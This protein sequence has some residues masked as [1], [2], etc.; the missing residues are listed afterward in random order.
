MARDEVP[1]AWIGQRVSVELRD[2]PPARVNV[3]GGFPFESRVGTL[4]SV[5][6]FGIELVRG[7]RDEF[8]PWSAVRGITLLPDT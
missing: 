8:H 6:E 2:P 3:A 5:N 1:G 4:R 7:A